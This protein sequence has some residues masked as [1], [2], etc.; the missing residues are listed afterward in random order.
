MAGFPSFFQRMY[1]LLALT[2]CLAAAAGLGFAAHRVVLVVDAAKDRTIPTQNDVIGCI[3][4]NSSARGSARR[5]AE[6]V[7]DRCR[8]KYESDVTAEVTLKG[9]LSYGVFCG[10]ILNQSRDW[11]VTRVSV[12]IRYQTLSFD[13]EISNTWL[14]PENFS[15]LCVTFPEHWR[16]PI[17]DTALSPEQWGWDASAVYGVRLDRK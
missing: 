11:I 2:G 15:Y 14:L 12:K 4:E 7:R 6:L 17:I 8:R 1:W 3:N 5:P 10:D 13:G 9:D 16:P